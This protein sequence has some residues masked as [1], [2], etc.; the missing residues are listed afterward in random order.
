MHRDS[1]KN[2]EARR[3]ISE[4][5]RVSGKSDLS[6]YH[7]HIPY[8]GRMTQFHLMSA[9][10]VRTQIWAVFTFGCDTG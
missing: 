8:A 2:E 1:S 3:K 4:S 7:R 9:L 10:S 5:D 6:Q